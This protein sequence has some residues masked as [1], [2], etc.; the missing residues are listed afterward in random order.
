MGLGLGLL[1]PIVEGHVDFDDG[2]GD[3]DDS[4]LGS[5]AGVGSGWRGSGR[6]RERERRTGEEVFIPG[7]LQARDRFCL[8][9]PQR[10]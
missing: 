6:E 9:H 2:H 4:G 5:V 10:A 8:S 1:T 3:G 7:G